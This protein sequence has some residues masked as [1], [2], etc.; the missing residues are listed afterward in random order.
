MSKKQAP[1]RCSPKCRGQ[2]SLAKDVL[3]LKEL[4]LAQNKRLNKLIKQVEQGCEV[5]EEPKESTVSCR[6]PYLKCLNPDRLHHLGL[7]T[8]TT[9]FRK[10]FG[11]VRFVFLGGT[12]KRMEKFAYF[13]MNAI[14]LRLH[15]GAK[16]KDLAEEG[17]RYSMFKVGPVLC[18]SHGMGGPSISILLHELIKMMCHAKCQDPVFFRLGTC[19]GIGVEPGTVIISTEALDGQMRNFHEVVVHGKVD[20]R[21]TKLNL[22][23]AQELK[24][25]SNPCEDGYDTITGTTLS[26]NDFYEGQSRLDGAFCEY[27]P[28]SKSNF[29]KCLSQKGIVNM[30]MESSVFASM[31]NQANIR[32]A[33][34]CVAI[35]NRLN[36]DQITTPHETLKEFD[37]R[38]QELVARYVRKILYGGDEEEDADEEEEEEGKD[39][40]KDCPEEVR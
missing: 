9:D 1:G 17:N 14:G 11:D 36:G 28:E 10:T 7:D 26:T 8:K 19:G 34:V 25:L 33:V 22:E 18:A 39:E 30:E 6:N 2:C 20:L 15:S 27:T 24:D 16:L 38:P 35:V 31:T 21:P 3:E 32:A 40:G 23:L 4:V 29:L 13:I 37:T 5:V 12:P